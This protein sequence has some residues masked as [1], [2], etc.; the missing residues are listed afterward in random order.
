MMNTVELTKLQFGMQQLL[1]DQFLLEAP[2]EFIREHMM[3]AVM[4]NF[5]AF[6]WAESK[7]AKHIEVKYPCDWK[8]A[9]KERWFPKWLLNRYPVKYKEIV[10]DV[11]AIYPEFRFAMKNTPGR[12][13][14]LKEDHSGW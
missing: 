3:S 5:H 6:V 7:S 13:T 14:I 2:V 8:E 4:A 10:L 11:K 9:F 12:L 1:S